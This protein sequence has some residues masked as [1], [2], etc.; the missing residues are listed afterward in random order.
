M[1]VNPG[2]RAC[3]GKTRGNKRTKGRWHRSSQKAEVQ[4]SKKDMK[5]ETVE[6]GQI[7][8]GTEESTGVSHAGD[9]EDLPLL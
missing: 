9:M 1:E 3:K 7:K 5:T 6:R 2:D 4:E 8:V